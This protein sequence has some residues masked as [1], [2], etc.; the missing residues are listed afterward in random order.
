MYRRYVRLISLTR[1]YPDALQL[2]EELDK[3]AAVSDSVAWKGGPNITRLST[4]LLLK[5]EKQN[6]SLFMGTAAV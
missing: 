1:R 2:F 3:D 6:A 5:P 4:A